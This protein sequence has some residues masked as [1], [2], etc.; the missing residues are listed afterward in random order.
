MRTTL[1]YLALVYSSTDYWLNAGLYLPWLLL[2]PDLPGSH[3]R[4]RSKLFLPLTNAEKY[5]KL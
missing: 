5:F 4:T 3:C 2:S 1:L